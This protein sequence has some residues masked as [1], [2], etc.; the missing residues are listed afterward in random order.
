MSSTIA[1]RSRAAVTGFGGGGAIA[2][3]SAAAKAPYQSLAGKM[4]KSV[5]KGVFAAPDSI[6]VDAKDVLIDPPTLDRAAVTEVLQHVTRPP[7]RLE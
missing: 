3:W 4:G 5:K 2:S 7:G 1:A 6:R